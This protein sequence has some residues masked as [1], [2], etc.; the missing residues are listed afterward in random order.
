M[1]V[2]GDIFERPSPA[3]VRGVF[4]SRR[5]ELVP[6]KGTLESGIEMFST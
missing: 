2:N 1:T 6:K 4:L 3:K 5:Y